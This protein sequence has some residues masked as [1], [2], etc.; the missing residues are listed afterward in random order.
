MTAALQATP[1]ADHQSAIEQ[2]I[3]AVGA[4]AFL[5]SLT[6]T[7]MAAL[8]YDWDLWARPSQQEPPGDWLTW[9]VLTGRGFGKTK[10]AAEWIRKQVESHRAHRIALVGRTP[11]DVRDVMIEGES[12]ILSVFPPHQRPTYEPS[13]RRITFHTGAIA[14]VFSSENPDQLR[15]PSHDTAWAD[16]LAT[17]KTVEA[18]SNLQFGLRL[19]NPRQI[20]TTTPRPI[21]QIRE[22]I[23]DPTTVVTTG[24]TYENRANLAPQFY[25][26]VIRRYEGTRLGQQELEGILLEEV[27]GALWQ[28]DM[29]RYVGGPGAPKKLP[30]FRRVVIG[31]D[32]TVRRVT[33]DE[34]EQGPAKC[35][36]SVAAHGVDDF[37]YILD[38]KSLRASPGRWGQEVVNTFFERLT[39]RVIGEQNQG[40]DMVRLTIHTINPNIPYTGVHA[41]TGKDARAEP[42]S[43][44]YT[45]KRVFH[46]R[47]FPDLE[48]E[49]CGWIPGVPNQPSPDR[50]DALVWAMYELALKPVWDPRVPSRIPA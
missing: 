27:P 38:D 11:A 21:R 14:T 25:D 5:T 8:A 20:V 32:P 2:A 46:V 10:L 36:I 13:K 35:G 42:V 16:E 18:F 40:G 17:F 45:Q 47:P 33:D 4:D 9:L 29:I 37:Y 48:D 24:T 50:L 19:G 23:D 15:G 3:A 34:P 12:G 6:A 31:V 39:D 30:A 1:V 26:Q 43:A 49:Q 44:L 7:E 28:R 41:S 22:L